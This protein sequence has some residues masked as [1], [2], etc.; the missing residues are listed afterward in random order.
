MSEVS[1]EVKELV[2]KKIGVPGGVVVSGRPSFASDA[3]IRYTQEGGELFPWRGEPEMEDGALW[4]GGTAEG[5]VPRDP[6][7]K[8]IFYGALRERIRRTHQ[9]KLPKPF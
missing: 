4:F 2:V 6:Q 8:N 7:D 1:K 3:F 5:W 9:R